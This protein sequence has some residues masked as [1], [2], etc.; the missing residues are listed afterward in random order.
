VTIAK[1]PSLRNGMISLYCCF[2]RFEKRKIFRKRAG[3]D[4]QISAVA[5]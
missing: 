5:P 1:R 3:R 4:G 2:Y